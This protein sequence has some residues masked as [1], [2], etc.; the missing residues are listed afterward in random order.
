MQRIFVFY[1]DKHEV[2]KIL[3]LPYPQSIHKKKRAGA[4][5]AKPVPGI[6]VL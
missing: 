1:P 4:L 2:L 5:L 6:Q 3:P